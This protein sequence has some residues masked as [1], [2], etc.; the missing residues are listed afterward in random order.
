M[1]VASACEWVSD[2]LW[3]MTRAENKKGWIEIRPRLKS[4]IL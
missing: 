1:D 2:W 4:N 3:M